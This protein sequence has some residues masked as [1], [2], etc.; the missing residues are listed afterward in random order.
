MNDETKLEAPAPVASKPAAKKPA[1]KP[2]AKK[3]AA[4]PAAKKPAAKK[5]AAKPAAKKPTAKPAAK[6]VDRRYEAE[7][8]TTAAKPKGEIMVLYT[9]RLQQTTIDAIV[10]QAKQAGI[11]HAALA[12]D[13][14]NKKYG[15]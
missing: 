1:A 3:P 11:T 7:R 8:R 6:L 12:R 14:L 10:K 13:C 5:P 9:I 2:A 15:N 4:K